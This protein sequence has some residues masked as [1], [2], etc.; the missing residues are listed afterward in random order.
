M[1]EKNLQKRILALC[2]EKGILAIK[3]DSS[4]CRGWP[5]I[6]AILPDGQVL[7]VELKTEAGVISA[8]QSRMHRNIK[9]NNGEIYVIRNY[10]EFERLITRFT[11]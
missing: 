3:V 7:F 11:E 5:D 4:S 6:T 1:S 10:T 9:K 8:L 2:A